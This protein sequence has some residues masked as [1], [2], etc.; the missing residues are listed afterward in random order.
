MT[1]KQSEIKK[2]SYFWIFCQYDREP[3]RTF[4]KV[5]NWKRKEE[6]NQKENGT[7]SLKTF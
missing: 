1:N 5:I 6:E 2:I 7:F 3:T 4:E